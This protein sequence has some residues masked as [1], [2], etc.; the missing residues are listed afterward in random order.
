MARRSRRTRE[1]TGP[2]RRPLPHH[3]PRRRHGA[4]AADRDDLR[5]GESPTQASAAK[6]GGAAIGGAILGAILGGGK[7][8]AIGGAIGAAAGAP[9]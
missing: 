7:G 5:E 3:H 4:A 6:I 8:A 2:A 1:G 9:R